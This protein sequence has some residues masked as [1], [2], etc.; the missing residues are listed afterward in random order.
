MIYQELLFFKSMKREVH[1]IHG[2]FSDSMFN[3]LNSFV[4]SLVD[5]DVLDKWIVAHAQR[6][7]VNEF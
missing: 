2:Y 4:C 1:S 7:N 3:S 6:D 5:G